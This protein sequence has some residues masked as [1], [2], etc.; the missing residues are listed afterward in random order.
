[1]YENLSLAASDAEELL[2]SYHAPAPLQSAQPRESSSAMDDNLFRVL[3]NA[4][5]ELGLE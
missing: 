5:E 4:V 1:M 2:G 3:S